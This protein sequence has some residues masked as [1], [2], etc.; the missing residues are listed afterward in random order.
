MVE[1]EAR[2]FSVNQSQS[3]AMQ[4]QSEIKI[5]FDT[6]L[7]TCSRSINKDGDAKENLLLLYC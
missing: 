1:K 4:N 5:S 7:K 2:V 6:Q 3:V